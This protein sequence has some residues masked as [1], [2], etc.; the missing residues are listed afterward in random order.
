MAF[1]VFQQRDAMD[2]GP[3]CLRMIANHHGR[4]FPHDLIRELCNIG[5]GG[6]SLQGMADAAERMGLRALAVKLPYATLADEVPLPCIVHWESNHFVVLHKIDRKGIHVADP[7][8]GMM[9]Y[10]P[11][12]FCAGWLA[13]GAQS[14]GV[15]LLLE[16][17]PQLAIAFTGAIEEPPQGFDYLLS[18]L[19]PHRRLF[20]QLGIGLMVALVFDLIFPFLTQSV[21]DKGIGNL[22]LSLIH[23]L[24]IGQL[25]IALGGV[26]LDMLQSWIMLHAGARVSLSLIADFLNKLMKLPLSFFDTRTV[27]DIMQRVDDHKRVNTLLTSSSMSVVF[28]LVSFVIF[29]AILAIYNLG[30][31]ALFVVITG[32]NIAWLTMFLK[33]RRMLDQKRFDLEA[34]ERN[35]FVELVNGVQEIKLQGLERSKRWE[36]EDISVKRFRVSSRALALKQVQRIG[37]TLLGQMRN[38]LITYLAAR[39]VLNGEMTLGMMLATQYIVGQLS[40]PVSNLIEFMHEAQ[41][42]KL[43]LERISEINRQQEEEHFT[44]PLETRF[45]AGR[46]LILNEVSFRYPGAPTNAVSNLSMIIPE[47]RVT[48]IVGSSGSG[49]TTLLKLLLGLHQP[50][51]GTIYL[52]RM[53]LFA[54]DTQAWRKRCGVVMQDGFIFSDTLAANIACTPT[55]PEPARLA[56]AIEL[57]ALNEFVAELP[58][59][60]QTRIGD[61]G[62]GLSG[63]QKQ[64]LLI[65]RALYK[66]PEFLFLD[67][68]TSSLDS[69]NERCIMD[70]LRHLFPGRTVVIIAHRLS[71]VKNADQIVVMEHGRIVESG[72]H[73]DLAY[74]RGHYYRLVSN[75]LE[76]EAAHV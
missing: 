47:G 29:G 15:L 27:G 34:Q 42:A 18:Y 38:V 48:A 13:K 71:T 22:D 36:W 30:I 24:L 25:I 32:L 40:A 55:P 61:D 33:K 66:G 9:I 59:G 21:V 16:P 70:N 68:A 31:L 11:Q 58:L 43:S 8:R 7:G 41:D 67:E 12:E 60:V 52:D 50:T 65:A 39:A 37:S 14:E 69:N 3:T 5:K 63:G 17:T 51:G 73:N 74:Q 4:L 57:A 62:R 76:L 49:K 2:C 28:S 64:R 56:A 23:L 75:Q 35:K 72:T 6:V 26:A 46:T 19:R 44:R 54:F 1:K 45:P 53:T 20:H 10:T